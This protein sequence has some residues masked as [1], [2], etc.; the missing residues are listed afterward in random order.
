MS[1]QAGQEFAPALGSEI[2]VLFNELVLRSG[3]Q[4][5]QDESTTNTTNEAYVT[6]SLLCRGL[7]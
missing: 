1:L 2:P 6:G 5:R 3:Y 4:Y 7:L